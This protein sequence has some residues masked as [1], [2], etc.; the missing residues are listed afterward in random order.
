MA[1]RSGLRCNGVPKEDRKPTV[2]DDR[3]R[4]LFSLKDELVGLEAQPWGKI[5]SWIAKATPIVRSDWPEHLDA[6]REVAA[7]PKWIRPRVRLSELQRGVTPTPNASDIAKNKEKA[8][9]VMRSVLGFLDGLQV[10]SASGGPGNIDLNGQLP[11]EPFTRRTGFMQRIGVMIGSPSDAGD[12]RQAITDALLRWN[13][14]NRDKGIILEPVKWET[15]ATPGLQGRPQGMINAELIP[16]SDILLAVF[17]SRAGSPTGKELSGTIEEIREFMQAGKYV[18]LYFYEGTVDI[19]TVDPDQLKTIAEFRKEI[20][21]HGL[22]AGYRD[23]GELREHI[24]CHMTSIVGRLSAPKLANVGERNTTAPGKSQSDDTSASGDG[25][26]LDRSRQS[27]SVDEKV[28]EVLNET[29]QRLFRLYESVSSYVKIIEGSHEAPKDGKLE[30]AGKANQEFWDYF[31]LNRI[32]VPPRLYE[33]IRTMA[34]KLTDIANGF[35]RARRREERGVV[36]DD[37]EDGWM[38]AFNSMENEA[39]PLFKSVVRQIQERLGVRDTEAP[40]ATSQ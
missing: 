29:Y 5:Q 21:G 32:Y 25:Q 19:R 37:E 36:R 39:G 30:V 40:D 33:E 34:G 31:L 35:T 22:T 15:H 28:A 8:E 1:V 27:F 10:I 16:V 38:T 4:R 23:I 20:Q 2:N 9:T 3:H 12:E 6:F 11:V 26:H 13:A 17:R 18:V 7:E 24:L 14:V